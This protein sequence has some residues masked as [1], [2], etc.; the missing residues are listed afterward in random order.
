[1]PA[2]TGKPTAVT[3][4]RRIESDTS[5]RLIVYIVERLVQQAKEVARIDHWHCSTNDEAIEPDTHTHASVIRLL[6]VTSSL[7]FSALM[8][9]R[10]FSSAQVMKVAFSSS[11]R[12]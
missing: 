12:G 4:L 11:P 8:I 6:S 5:G 7:G 2:S 3:G 1:M 10:C 9:A